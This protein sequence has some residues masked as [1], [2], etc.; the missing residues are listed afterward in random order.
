MESFNGIQNL[1]TSLN[2]H[3]VCFSTYNILQSVI[4]EQEIL[5]MYIFKS[6]KNVFQFYQHNSFLAQIDAK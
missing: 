1:A 3:L 6:V 4:N 5:V 2:D